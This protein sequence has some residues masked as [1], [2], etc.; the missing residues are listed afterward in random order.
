MS[1]STWL[2]PKEWILAGT[3]GVVLTICGFLAVHLVETT[4]SAINRLDD[5]VAALQTTLGGNQTAV[6]V[7]NSQGGELRGDIQQTL[8]LTQQN[9]KAL[10]QLS[11]DLSYVKGQLAGLRENWK[12]MSIPVFT[13]PPPPQ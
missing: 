9:G 12:T 2:A 1:I 4:D 8:A 10:D 6:A 3:L 5:R 11:S 7:L 13:Q